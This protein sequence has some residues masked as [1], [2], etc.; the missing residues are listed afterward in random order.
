VGESVVTLVLGSWPR[1]EFVKVRA[2]IELRSHISCSRECKR[3]W[4]NESSHS[5]MNSHFGNWSPNG[6][7]NL[8][9][10]ILGVKTHY[11]KEFLISL[12][13][14]WNLNVWNGLAWPIWTPKTQVMAKRKAGSQIGNLTPNHKKSRIA[15]I[16]LHAGGMQHIV[17]KLLT[18]AI[19]LL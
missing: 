4:G 9:T 3:V 13:S 12:K 11:I 8:Q 10:E 6:L 7:P 16:S 1:Q 2:K 19:T 14:S 17:K 5:Q 18:R 15:P